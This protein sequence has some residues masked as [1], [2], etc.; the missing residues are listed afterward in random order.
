MSIIVTVR[1]KGDPRRV[2]EHAAADPEAMRAIAD[3]AKQH[4][5]IAQAGKPRRRGLGRLIDND[6]EAGGC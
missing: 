2:E 4:G 6:R 1:A 3:R 5:V